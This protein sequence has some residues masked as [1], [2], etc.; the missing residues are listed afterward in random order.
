ML[1]LLVKN[2]RNVWEDES[3]QGMVEYGLII[4]VVAIVLITALTA[5]RGQLG[6]LFDGIRAK[7][8]GETPT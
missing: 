8:V 7:L 2:F 5:F 4:A 1:S 6:S 3:G